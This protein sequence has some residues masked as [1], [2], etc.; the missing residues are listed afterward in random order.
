MGCDLRKSLNS[1]DWATLADPLD[2]ASHAL[3]RSDE[4]LLRAPTHELNRTARLLALRRRIDRQAP[5]TIQSR[6]GLLALIGR[7][8][9]EFEPRWMTDRTAR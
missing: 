5:A 6:K 4:R 8:T 9:N 1:P 2:S 3:T 7:Q